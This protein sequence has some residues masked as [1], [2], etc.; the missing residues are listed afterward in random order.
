[1]K[2]KIIVII[3]ATATGKTGLAIK[4][5]NTFSGEIVNAD[6]FQIYKEIAIGTA[7]ASEEERKQATFHLDGEL[8]IYDEWNIK[9][10]QTKAFEIIDDIIARNKMPIIVGGSF[11]Y[12]E[13]LVKN[14]NLS[15]TNIRN[16]KYNDLSVEELFEKANKI[17]PIAANKIINNKKRLVRMLQLFDNS[18]FELNAQ[19]EPKY[20][21][22]YVYTYMDREKIY[23][24]INLRCDIMIKQG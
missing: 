19:N 1:M 18:E 10:F 2:H 17:N 4:L 12:V 5:A 24:R 16:D 20:E 3:G 22:I 14:Y 15:N 7:R 9:V 8:S 6:A 21:P 23:E 13:A 11:L